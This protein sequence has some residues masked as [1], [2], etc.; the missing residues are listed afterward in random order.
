MRALVV[1]DEARLA[2][3]LRQGLLQ[4]GFVVDI[5]SDGSEGLAL[6]LA[7]PYDVIILDVMLPE[8]DGFSVCRELRQ[9]G[10][11]SPI[12]MLSA[13]S[14]VEDRVRGLETG[15]DDYL[16]KPFAFSELLARVRALLRR[17]QP[18]A[19]RVLSVGDLSLDPITRIVRRGERKVDLTQKEFALLEYLMRHAG[20]A[21]TRAMIAEHVWGLTWDRLTNVIDVYVSHLR[22]KVESSPD[23]RLIHAVRGVGY[24]IRGDDVDGA[25]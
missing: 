2:Q 21:V 1:E 23:A 13:R 8:R 17:R 3:S 4:D 9:K 5:A 16:A 15:A 24:M 6:G 11:E 22:A 19:L 25:A 12:L 20:H 14:V 18:A 10:V 7:T